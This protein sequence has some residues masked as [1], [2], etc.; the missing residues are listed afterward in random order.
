ME[1]GRFLEL[2][3]LIFQMVTLSAVF[4]TLITNQPSKIPMYYFAFS[5]SLGIL[6]EFYR[7]IKGTR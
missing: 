1:R 5:L 2:I 4:V 6:R 7:V 3:T